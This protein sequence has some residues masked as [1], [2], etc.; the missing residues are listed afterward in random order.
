[1]TKQQKLTALKEVAQVSL[2]R[3]LASLAQIQSEISALDTQIHAISSAEAKRRDAITSRTEKSSD[4]P[5]DLA[6]SMGVDVR[7]QKLNT[8]KRR[9]LLEEKARISARLEEQLSL[10]QRAFG[11]VDALRG[12][13]KKLARKQR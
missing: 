11:K 9:G 7:W 12:I 10:T 3:E 5:L 8:A 2:E 4:Q 13:A 1:M 6:F